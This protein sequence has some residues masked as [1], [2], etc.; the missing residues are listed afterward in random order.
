MTGRKAKLTIGILFICIVVII[1]GYVFRIDR[2]GLSQISW[3]DCVRIN[4]TTYFNFLGRERPS[5]EISLID[6]KIG[7]VKFTVSDHVHNANYRFRNGD[8][9]YLE[10]GTEIYRLASENNAV[11]V[12]IGER[13]FSYK[14][15]L[16]K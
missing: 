15:D 9:S 7:E 5:V 10:T 8:A 16:Y 12:K 13:Y 2:F 4:N 6:E 3:V 11:A 1:S 14:A